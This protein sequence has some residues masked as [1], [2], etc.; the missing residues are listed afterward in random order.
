MGAFEEDREAAMEV[1]PSMSSQEAYG[2]AM[3]RTFEALVWKMGAVEA[4]R[5]EW[6]S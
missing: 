2:R 5:V 3:M 4:T 6:Q 1:G